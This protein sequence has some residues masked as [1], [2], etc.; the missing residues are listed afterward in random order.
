MASSSLSPPLS[1]DTSTSG[2]SCY[3]YKNHKGRNI[4]GYRQTKGRGADEETSPPVAPTNAR[5]HAT[6]L[7]LNHPNAHLPHLMSPT[8]LMG[9]APSHCLPPLRDLSMH[10][11]HVLLRSHP[12]LHEVF[13]VLH[14]FRPES[15][16]IEF[17]YVVSVNI[18]QI[19]MLKSKLIKKLT[20]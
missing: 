12:H 4:Q 14:W 8:V 13:I 19:N 17:I 16:V 11:L 20:A 6:I 9:R 15:G 7:L 2:N 18:D 1:G 3:E 10:S 5:S